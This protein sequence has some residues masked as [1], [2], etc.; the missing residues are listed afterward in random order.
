VAR[1]AAGNASTAML[2]HTW[3]RISDLLLTTDDPVLRASVRRVSEHEP[4]SQPWWA[5]IRAVASR[6][7][8]APGGSG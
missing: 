5:A 1:Y 3:D 6:H 7:L 8:Y 2:A 4:G